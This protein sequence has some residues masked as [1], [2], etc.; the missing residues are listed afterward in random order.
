M[1]T[2]PLLL[3]SFYRA[4][5]RVR[6]VDAVIAIERHRRRHRRLPQSLAELVPEFLPTVPLDQIDG[7]PLRYRV[8]Q[9]VICI[10]SVANETDD[11]GTA[12][13]I[14]KL[15][16]DFGYRISLKERR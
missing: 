12:M 6:S 11:G 2:R 13:V 15:F 9:G 16:T 8:E 14:E 5:T 4:E 3:N 7:Q 10:Y 1:M